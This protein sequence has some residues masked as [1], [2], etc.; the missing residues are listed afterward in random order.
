MPVPVDPRYELV[1]T[2]GIGKL[3]IQNAQL[4][5]SGMYSCELQSR[6]YGTILSESPVIVTVNDGKFTYI[7]L[8]CIAWVRPACNWK[9]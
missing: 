6:L 4:G 8:W 1:S 9:S 3:T 7:T 2:L 5:D